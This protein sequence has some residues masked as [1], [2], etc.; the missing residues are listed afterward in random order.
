MNSTRAL[1]LAALTLA[2]ATLV[3]TAGAPAAPSN[4]CPNGKVRF[5][6]EPYDSGPKFTGAYQALTKALQTNLSCPVKLT[7]TNNY[8]AEV[9]AMRAKQLDVGE[10]GPLG[11]I[12]A[13]KLA[14]AQPVAVFGT[15]QRK[16][17]TYTAA[18]WVPNSSTITSV[19]GLKG[20]T[21]AFSDPASTSG[22]LLPR[23]A[24]IQA[25]LNPDTDVKIEF[26]G[27]HSASLLALTNGKVDAGEVN[28]QQQA[29]AS[30]AGQFDTTQYRTIWRSKPIP[31]DPIT[32]R[33]DLSSAFKA[34]FKTALLKLTPAQLKLVDTE[35][36]VDSG[37][38]IP[39]TDAMFQPIRDVVTA[40][41]L[42]I[43]DIG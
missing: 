22:N 11:Y 10:F 3:A 36:G 26:A 9:E 33:G 29:T 43:K 8:T 17:V 39:G 13:H 18:L 20:H 7:I 35:L 27:S 30:A 24:L 6:V 2:C 23:Y 25:G 40:E 19:A 21:I 41:N 14:N 37:P 42:Q 34:A 15:A 4:V 32:V 12:F 28:S 5:A 1:A 31:N 16:P 38:M